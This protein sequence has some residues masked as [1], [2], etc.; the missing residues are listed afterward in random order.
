MVPEGN[1]SR[2]QWFPKAMVSRRQWFPGRQWFP[3]AMVP[4]GSLSGGML[5]EGVFSGCGMLFRDFEADPRNLPCGF[6]WI[7]SDSVSGTGAAPV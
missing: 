4:E 7:W 6:G 5:P 1:G 3:K 2:R